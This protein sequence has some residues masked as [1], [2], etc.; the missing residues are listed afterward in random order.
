MIL[1]SILNRGTRLRTREWHPIYR[2]I[3]LLDTEAGTVWACRNI[4]N[5]YTFVRSTPFYP[6]RNTA[7]HGQ[8]TG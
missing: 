8:K 7:K 4:G 6:D 5:I 2:S 3:I 1:E